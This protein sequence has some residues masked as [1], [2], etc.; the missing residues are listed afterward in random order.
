[1][2]RRETP[3]DIEKIGDIDKPIDNGKR[4]FIKNV[5]KGIAAMAVIPAVFRLLDPSEAF[6]FVQNTKRRWVFLVDTYKCIG[7]GFCVKAC[8]KENEISYDSPVSR[9]WVER[10]VVK[11]DGTTLIDSPMAGR[12]GFT[13]PDIEGQNVPQGQ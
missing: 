12:D 1:M 13:S 9:T 5:C 6:A 2:K 7:C 10:Y 4:E 11:K 8:K 3:M